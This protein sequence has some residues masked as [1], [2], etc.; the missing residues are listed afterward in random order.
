MS[1]HACLTK[2]RGSCNTNHGNAVKQY[3]YF[4]V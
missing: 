3:Y 4:Y 1:P 2:S